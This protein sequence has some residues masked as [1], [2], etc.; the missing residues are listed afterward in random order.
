MAHIAIYK[1]ELKIDVKLVG[2]G[3]IYCFVGYQIVVYWIAVR[4][5]VDIRRILI[6]G[7]GCQTVNDLWPNWILR[8][9]LLFT[10]Y[11]FLDLAGRY[12][13]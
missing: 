11:H 12:L 7:F 9:C 6:F 13:V 4:D 10:R 1:G 5:R 8:K 2:M 3:Q